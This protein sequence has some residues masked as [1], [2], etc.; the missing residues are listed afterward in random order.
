MSGVGQVVRLGVAVTDEGGAALNA[1]TVTCVLTLPD[2]TTTALDVLNPPAV[3]GHYRV[4]YVPAVAGLFTF[5][6]LTTAPATEDEGSFYVNEPGAVGIIGL[7]EGKRLLRIPPE[8]TRYDDDIEEEIRSATMLAEQESRQVLLRRTVTETRDLGNTWRNGVALT[9]A[10]V[11]RVVMVERLH[12]SGVVTEVV[13]PPDV[14]GD[15]A[16]IVRA[17]RP[18]VLWG[19]VRITYVAGPV[20]L[21]PAH[22]DA[23]RYLLQHL[24]ANRGGNTARPRVGGGEEAPVDPQDRTAIPTRVRELLGPRAP[25]VG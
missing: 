12:S 23:V 9:R 20:V 22:R 8:D 13:T 11:V 17:M 15:E 25:L 24:W 5:V 7:P 3:T 14:W 6:W 21:S 18:A 19:L 10:P 16:G 2:G 1:A 4:D